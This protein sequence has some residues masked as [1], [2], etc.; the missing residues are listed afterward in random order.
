MFILSGQIGRP[1]FQATLIQLVTSMGLL[2]VASIIV[3]MLM[4]YVM[5]LRKRYEAYKFEDTQDFTDL[6]RQSLV[7]GATGTGG[8]GGG[9]TA[10][11]GGRR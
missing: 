8:G 11:N 10:T 4:L 5:P 2:S 9:G 3:E 1:T 7:G 6:R